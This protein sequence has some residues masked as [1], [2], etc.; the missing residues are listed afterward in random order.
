MAFCLWAS[1][2][3]HRNY[4]A[5]AW[6]WMP[7]LTAV[8]TPELAPGGSRYGEL[9]DLVT[10]GLR[11]WGRSVYRVGPSRGYLVTLACEG[12][13]PLKLILR[14]QTHLRRYLKG[15]LEEFKH[16]GATET[17]AR[18]LAERLRD[19]LPRAWRREAVYE[20]SGELIEAVW[21]FQDELGET[22]TPVQD[23]DCK[24]PGW[25]EE[26][27]VRISDQVARTLL[28]DLLIEAVQVARRARIDVRWNV[29]LV[30]VA[31]GDWE[32]RG[33]FHLP[34]TISEEA[35]NR[36]F[37]CWP[38]GETPRRFT[39]GVQTSTGRFRALALGTER[40]TD[41][42]GR[43]FRLE[44]FSAAHGAETNWLD[45]FTATA[46]PHRQREVSHGSVSG[47]GGSWRC[48]VGLCSRGVRW[49]GAPHQS[50]GR[51]RNGAGQGAGRFRGSGCRSGS[52]HRR[53][54]GRGEAGSG[55]F[56][57]RGSA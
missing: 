8:G 37:D 21:M 40:R 43:S 42:N 47:V 19:R 33:S 7:L 51:P 53:G 46:G 30:P 44:P 14:E 27:P 32:L 15:V 13:L 34:A 5:G 54:R 38:Q 22:D 49:R 16:F 45:G 12:G 48:R 4:E 6:R 24:H 3:W 29:D 23:L 18:D 39:L 20:L 57:M 1:E 17:P 52:R 31:D 50:S 36:L 9:Q 2:W 28:N 11:A 35:F 25:R 56:A 26:L 41:N 55:R 10:R